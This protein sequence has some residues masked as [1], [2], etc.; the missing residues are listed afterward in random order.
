MRNAQ[1]YKNDDSLNLKYPDLRFRGSRYVIN[2][3]VRAAESR[4]AIEGIP[5]TL[6]AA[7]NLGN[8]GVD[9]L[10]IDESKVSSLSGVEFIMTS[11]YPAQKNSVSLTLSSDASAWTHVYKLG[12]LLLPSSVLVV[13]AVSI[14]FGW[15]EWFSKA[16]GDILL[17]E[18]LQV[19]PVE[20]E[21]AS[22]EWRETLHPMT[23]RW[24]TAVAVLPWSID[25]RKDDSVSFSE[26][27]SGDGFFAVFPH[28]ITAI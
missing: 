20:V 6:T 1:D 7:E 21:V 16:P 26:H 4:N 13:P 18:K 22:R 25:V 3:K 2:V 14:T 19:G 10:G 8:I 28:V 17:P 11:T 5:F 23:Y 12:W 15:T 27:V 9:I 24:G